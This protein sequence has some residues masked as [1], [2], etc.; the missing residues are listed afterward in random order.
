MFEPNS[1]RYEVDAET[2]TATLT[3]DRPERLNALTFEVYDELRRAFYALHD[4]DDVRVVIL[5]GT[6]RGFCT[7]G[8]VEDIIGRLFERDMR[9]LL[10]FTRMTCDLILAIR[11]CRKP[12]I[13][14]LNGTVA[15][16]GAVIATACDMRV[17]SE[18]AKIAYLFTR[19]GLSGADMGAAWMLPRIV[20]LAKA[21]ELLMTGD[22]ISAEE[23]H[24]IGLYNRVVPEGAALEEAQ[25]LAA[26]LAKGPSFA[27]EI[28]KDSLNREASMDLAGAL[29]AEAQIQA[30][31]MLHPD[32]RESYDAFVEKRD[33]NFL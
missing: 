1:F 9:G 8:D 14:A 5:T 13:G 11:R 12:V 33:P 4:Q 22:F 24:R 10:E 28:T 29:E 6:G 3:L 15:G 18:T 27:L 17:G 7:G 21:S 32:F 2:R 20:G 26:K 30:A 19:V 31:L 16:A 25:T 23:A